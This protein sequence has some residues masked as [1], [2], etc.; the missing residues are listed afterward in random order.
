[1][2]KKLCKDY[3]IFMFDLDRTVFD[4]FTK[5]S[6]PIWAKQMIQPL[7]RY[8]FCFKTSEI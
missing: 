3:D 4:T 8:S 6:E 2:I 1:M 5:K 7:E